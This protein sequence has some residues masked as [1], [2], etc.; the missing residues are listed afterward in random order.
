MIPH[1]T[2]IFLKSPLTL[3]VKCGTLKHKN[4]PTK[5]SRITQCRNESKKLDNVIYKG[6]ISGSNIKEGWEK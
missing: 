5:L 3:S 1:R 2:K 6:R 4:R